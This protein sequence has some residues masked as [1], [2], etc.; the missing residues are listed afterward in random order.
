[1]E[2]KRFNSEQPIDCILDR[3][4]DG[5]TVVIKSSTKKFVTAVYIGNGRILKHPD[6]FFTTT[7]S[8]VKL[9]DADDYPIIIRQIFT[10]PFER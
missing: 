4:S 6:L 10:L 1:V 7:F 9:I 8:N 5:Y 3:G 2:V